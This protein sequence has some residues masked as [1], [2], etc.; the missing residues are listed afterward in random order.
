MSVF[1]VF[2]PARFGRMFVSDAANVSRDPTLLF[3]V[4]LSVVPAIA[5]ALWRQDMDAAALGAFGL[6]DL[7]RYV[8]PIVI[9]LPAFLVS[10]VT[11]FLF[12]EDRDEKT[13]L[14]LDITPVGRRDSD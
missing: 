3:A 10:W 5:F 8:L 2:A 4:L 7:S 9:C 11:G 13:L 6:P 1:S 14:A 12:L